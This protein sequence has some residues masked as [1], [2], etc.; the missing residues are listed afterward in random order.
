MFRFVKGSLRQLSGSLDLAQVQEG[1]YSKNKYPCLNSDYVWLWKF[2][3]LIIVTILGEALFFAV[4][5]PVQ[6]FI[7]K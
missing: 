4:E 1:L 2:A 3:A 6:K 7:K 5:Q